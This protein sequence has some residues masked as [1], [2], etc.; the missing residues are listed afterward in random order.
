MVAAEFS[1]P[2]PPPATNSFA[3]HYWKHAKQRHSANKRAK[4]T[5]SVRLTEHHLNNGVLYGYIPSDAYST[6]CTSNAVMIGDPFI[7][8]S[9]PSIKI[10][11]VDNDC[12]TPGST[13]AKLHQPVREPA[14]AVEIVPALSGQYLLS[15]GKF[16]EAGY[17]SICDGEE[18]NLLRWA[19]FP[20][21]C[22]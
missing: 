12:R 21:H 6:A 20:N 7:Q 22:V 5:S 2:T 19:H 11:S 13:V 14:W 15:G 4:H 8:T 18:V 17:I 3:Q 9:Q 10:F 16:S 1:S